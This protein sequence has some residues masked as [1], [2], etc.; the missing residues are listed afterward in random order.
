[1]KSS[2]KINNR[3]DMLGKKLKFNTTKKKNKKRESKRKPKS[4]KINLNK[5]AKAALGTIPLYG[6]IKNITKTKAITN[7]SKAMAGMLPTIS[8]SVVKKATD[9]NA[10]RQIQVK[11]LNDTLSHGMSGVHTLSKDA[12][13]SLQ[14]THKRLLQLSNKDGWLKLHKGWKYKRN[15]KFVTG[16]Q[17]IDGNCYYFGTDEYMC[18]GWKVIKGN[19]YY[20][21][22][23]ENTIT[24]G[25]K[26]AYGYMWTGWRKIDKKWYYLKTK[27][28]A[29]EGANKNAYGYIWTGWRKIDGD[30]YYFQPDGN[31]VQSGKVF[32]S[33]N[34]VYTV[35]ENGK[36]ISQAE[37][38]Y[39]GNYNLLV[40]SVLDDIEEEAL[41]KPELY[42]NTDFIETQSAFDKKLS[43]YDFLGNINEHACGAI[44]MYN[45]LHSLGEDVTFKK[46]ITDIL[47]DSA[48]QKFEYRESD[49]VRPTNFAGIMGTWPCYIPEYMSRYGYNAQ[50]KDISWVREDY[51]LKS[52]DAYIAVYIWGIG[53]HYE[54]LIP[55]EDGGLQAYNITT[56]YKDF[57]DYETK[58]KETDNQFVMWIYEI[59]RK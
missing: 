13:N 48:G 3:L 46:I 42:G 25:D 24:S 35:D 15:G 12:V 54:A 30:W 8:G 32:S 36:L 18:T 22:T 44:S 7:I 11:D 20:F 59:D 26:N 33:D 28:D 52:H 1:M 6:I 17:D 51:D 57:S 2:L 56:K 4:K 16:W 10:G 21:K 31:L 23:E 45:V 41:K 58:K 9:S 29:S 19:R 53:G 39:G 47:K 5:I 34:K 27:Q 40:K 49:D 37:S 55:N 43:T 50:Y 14:N 38:G